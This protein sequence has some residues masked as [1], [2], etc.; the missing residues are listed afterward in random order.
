MLLRFL[1]NWNYDLRAPLPIQFFTTSSVRIRI[2]VNNPSPLLKLLAHLHYVRTEQFPIQ[3]PMFLAL[4][5]LVSTNAIQAG[6]GE[7]MFGKDH[8]DRDI[9]STVPAAVAYGLQTIITCTWENEAKTSRPWNRRRLLREQSWLT[10]RCIRVTSVNNHDFLFLF[11][12][13]SA[14]YCYVHYHLCQ[15]PITIY[16]IVLFSFFSFFIYCIKNSIHVI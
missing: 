16:W 13:I 9:A 1:Q 15:P 14:I 5:F 2:M 12:F 10:E 8:F 4:W 6:E 3:S 7:A 11:T